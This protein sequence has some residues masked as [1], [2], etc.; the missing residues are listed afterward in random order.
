MTR[1]GAFPK[2]GVFDRSYGGSEHDGFPDTFNADTAAMLAWGLFDLAR[3][4][5]NN[6]FTYFVRDD[7]LILYRGPETGQYGRMLTVVAQYANY[8]G[9]HAL[10]LR[11]RRRLDAVAKLLLALRAKALHMPGDDPAYGMIVGWSEADACLD[12][13]PPR[14]MQPYL[15][16]STEAARGFEDLGAV[17]EEVG[18]KKHQPELARWGQELRRE[19]R[20]LTTDLQQAIARSML[21]NTQ[22]PCLPAIAGVKE[23]FHIAVARDKLDPR[24]QVETVVNYRAA[25]H[26]IILGIPTVYGYDTHEWGGFLS[27]GHAYGLLQHDFVREYL[28][29]LYSLMAHQYTRG[30]WTAPETRLVD[31]KRFAAPYCTPAQ[32]VAPLLT[33]WMLVFE[34]PA[35]DTLWLAKGTPRAWLEDGQTIAVTRAPTPWGRL[36]LEES[37]PSSSCRPCHRPRGLKFGYGFPKATGCAR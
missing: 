32:M 22:P 5:I 33:R 36:R 6:Y 28:L 8:T 18:R 31:P 29:T 26:D 35:A 7:G 20:S 15:S 21:T 14:Y 19:S 12:P 23:P 4:Y 16:N 13:D 17:W 24:S 1:V 27:Y 11:H 25:H 3:D 34:E 30:T 9:D 2:Y 10:L 37:R